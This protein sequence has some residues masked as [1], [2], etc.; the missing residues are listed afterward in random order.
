MKNKLLYLITL[1]TVVFTIAFTGCKKKNND[2]ITNNIG[3]EDTTD[4]DTV[5]NF[6]S[7]YDVIIQA[8]SFDLLVEAVINAGL[9]ETLKQESGNYT[10]FLPTD[11][12]FEVFM[13]MNGYTSVDDIPEEVLLYHLLGNKVVNSGDFGGYQ[14][15]M[16]DC[17]GML[18]LYISATDSLNGE[19][20]ILQKDVE[21]D[22]GVIH[23]IDA[24]LELPSVMT[25]IKID[26]EVKLYYQAIKFYGSQFSNDYSLEEY[27]SNMVD[28]EEYKFTVFAPT[29]EGTLRFFHDQSSTVN[30]WQDYKTQLNGNM[31]VILNHITDTTVVKSQI[32]SD[33]ELYG[34][35]FENQLVIK[36]NTSN[37]L[38]LYGEVSSDHIDLTT[39]NYLSGDIRA[40]N[41]VLHKVDAVLYEE[42]QGQPLPIQ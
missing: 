19:V 31:D 1:F 9:V 41:G 37:G 7:L 24:V 13:D 35:Y 30:T 21:A 11:Y 4:V 26:P 32:S 6:T 34:N 27:L 42:G 16:S 40:C 28:L 3:Q 23:V 18:S 8:D 15:T 38:S 12:A 36:F 33:T 14:T 17:N 29:D 2:D 25:F 22:N 10:I 20:A 39:A 5:N